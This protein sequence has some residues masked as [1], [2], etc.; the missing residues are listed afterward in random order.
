MR[1]REC[2]LLCKRVAPKFEQMK[3]VVA[4]D[5]GGERHLSRERKENR[6]ATAI[7]FQPSARGF[8]ASA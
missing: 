6:V 8:S 4:L 1:S 2:R 7:H 5:R 3:D